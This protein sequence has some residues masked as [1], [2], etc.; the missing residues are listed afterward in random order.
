M[1]L[2]A[3]ALVIALASTPSLAR[4]AR[5]PAPTSE[6]KVENMMMKIDPSER[7]I[8]VCSVA[9]TD[10]L[11][12]DK[13]RYKADRAVMDA[14]S[15]A[16]ITDDKMNGGGAAFRSRGAWY[17]FSFTCEASPDHLKVLSFTYKVGDKIPKD[18]LEQYGLW[19]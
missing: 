12:R 13:S 10:N 5:R 15:P 2:F 19:Q 6:Q 7:F 9:A 17:Q 8:Q 11:A 1:K 18:K 14:I 3:L 16:E 4:S